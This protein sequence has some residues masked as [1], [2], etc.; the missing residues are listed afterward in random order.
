M[1]TRLVSGIKNGS[2]D[3]AVFICD[4]ITD[5]ADL[6]TTTAS[7]VSNGN[8]YNKCAVGSI[9]KVVNADKKFILNN[10]DEW[11][12]WVEVASEQ[13]ESGGEGENVTLPS[14]DWEL[15]Y[16]EYELNVPPA[17]D[18]NPIGTCVSNIDVSK[19]KEFSIDTLTVPMGN[20]IMIAFSSN[21]HMR[22]VGVIVNQLDQSSID[23]V[24]RAHFSDNGK[25]LISGQVLLDAER[26]DQYKEGF[27]NNFEDS[28]MFFLDE[29]VNVF[30][31]IERYIP[32]E[33]FALDDGIY[34]TAFADTEF[35]IRI[36]GRR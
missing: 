31:Q 36:Y 30:P 15:V 20:M 19:Y 1:Y 18:N 13:P 11:I 10:S 6:P 26:Y 28:T 7:G 2:Y 5:L 3:F 8:V 22:V 9:A 21:N 23:K 33:V 14:N 16:E 25:T 27:I 17:S 32:P 4:D 24:C 34:I 35:N 29:R 12:E